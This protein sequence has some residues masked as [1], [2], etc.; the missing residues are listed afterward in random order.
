MQM[1]FVHETDQ[2]VVDAFE[3]GRLV[4]HDLR[5]VVGRVKNIRVAEDQQRT[6]RRIVDQL[7][8]RLENGHASAFAAS[9]RARDVKALFRQQIVEVVTGNAPRN[10]RVTLANQRGIFVAQLLSACG[11]FPRAD[12]HYG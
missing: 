11:K 4:F 2:L 7:H 1:V 3:T 10:F 12:R 6:D 8:R 9:E 5:A